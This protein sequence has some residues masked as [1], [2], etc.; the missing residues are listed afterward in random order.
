MFEKKDEVRIKSEHLE[1]YKQ[2]G[3]A[4]LVEEIELDDKH[5]EFKV[6]VGRVIAIQNDLAQ[7]D[8]WNTT[9]NKFTV[10]LAHLELVTKAS[11]RVDTAAEPIGMVKEIKPTR[12]HLLRAGLLGDDE[13]MKEAKEVVKRQVT[14]SFE[15]AHVNTRDFNV[16]ESNYADFKIQPWDIWKEY[17]LNPWDADVV[18][19]ILRTKKGQERKLDYEKIIHICQERIRQLEE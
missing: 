12:E 19:R 7:V 8:F 4:G 13:P 6:K 1:L 17:N 10:K 3:L 18:K 9:P 2:M 11:E 16:G 15:K 14:P 5:S